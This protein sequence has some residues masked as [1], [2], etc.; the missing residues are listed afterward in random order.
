MPFSLKIVADFNHFIL[1]SRGDED[2]R[3]FSARH[4]DNPGVCIE[5]LHCF[6]ERNF[7]LRYSIKDL[8]KQELEV[9]KRDEVF[10]FKGCVGCLEKA[11]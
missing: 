10:L 9:F 2:I 3:P 4:A 1:I 6:T 8:C 7:L 5:E 11:R